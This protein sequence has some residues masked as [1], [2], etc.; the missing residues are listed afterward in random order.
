MNNTPLISIIVPIYNTQKYLNNC[1]QSIVF[2]TYK[3]LEI[4][5]VDDGSCDN[6]PV[7]CDEWRKKDN[8]IIT[9]HINNSGQSVARNI[10]LNKIK[11][12][13]VCFFDSDDSVENNYVEIMY[14]KLVTNN[15]DAVVCNIPNKYKNLVNGK[16]IYEYILRDEIGGQLWRWIFKKECWNN[17]RFPINKYAED[18]AVIYKV[19][20]EKNIGIINKDL[21]HYN[22]NNQ[23][24]TSNSIKN[25]D[26]NII[27]RAIM[28]IDRYYWIRTNH[29]SDDLLK[30]VLDKAVVFCACVI[31]RRNKEY[32]DIN[33]L[34]YVKEFI[35]K[36]R[37]SIF[38]SNV[39]VKY[40]ASCYLYYRFPFL[41]ELICRILNK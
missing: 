26:K 16:N 19:I 15:F 14:H 3:N 10:A 13:Y 4:V 6:C 5:L 39:S 20:F 12:N 34:I 8:R 32:Y 21:Y 9:I 29:L 18:A 22:V 40:K 1:I 37:R 25:I 11:G 28:F 2:Q 27:D 33:D 17:I 41:F 24:S 31:I 23:S 38:L 36:E 35:Y 7:I 30:I